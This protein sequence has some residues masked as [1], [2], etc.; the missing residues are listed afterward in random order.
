MVQFMLNILLIAH[1]YVLENKPSRM[2]Y[3][4]F[5]GTESTQITK[6]FATE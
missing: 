4:Y 1:T 3:I 2:S 6:L 5:Y